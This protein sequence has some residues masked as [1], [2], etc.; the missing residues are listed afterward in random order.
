MDLF[1]FCFQTFSQVLMKYHSVTV[2]KTLVTASFRG[3]SHRLIS[4]PPHS[5]VCC[6]CFWICPTALCFSFLTTADVAFKN[7]NVWLNFGAQN[8]VWG[9]S[10]CL[11]HWDICS[12]A[13]GNILYYRMWPLIVS[14][15]RHQGLWC[16]DSAAQPKEQTISQRFGFSHKQNKQTWYSFSLLSRAISSTC[17]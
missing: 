7:L 16:S 14:R 6:A 8:Q 11:R 1:L 13:Q 2:Q 17:F 3:R 9:F 10:F 12:Q 4:A 15:Y 5:S